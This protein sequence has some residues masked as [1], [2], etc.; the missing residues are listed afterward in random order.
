VGTDET[1]ALKESVQG[2]F[3]AAYQAQ[4]PWSQL[5]LR[6]RGAILGRFAPAI[7]ESRHAL[8]RLVTSP[9]R[10]DFRETISSELLPLA[11]AAKW[12]SSKAARILAIRYLD[13]GGSPTWLGRIRSEVHR[14]PHG[15]VLIIGTWNY[16]IFLTGVQILHAL[17]AGNAV[18]IKP[19][20]GCEEVTRAMVRMLVQCGVPERLLVVLDS[21]IEAAK[22]A[23]DIGVDHVIM[24]GSSSSGRAVLTQAIPSLTSA[25][26][27]LSGSDA[28]YVLPGADLHRVCDLL[29]FGLRLNGGATC[30]A[31]RR[32]FIPLKAS[33]VFHRVFLERLNEPVQRDWRTKIESSTHQRLWDGVADALDKGARIFSGQ[34]RQELASS[35]PVPDFVAMGHLVLTDV[36]TD[37]KLYSEDIFAPLIMI[38][39][40]ENW[41]GAL[42]ADSQC[43]FALSASIFGPVEDALRLVP[44]ISAG[45]VTIN[46]LIVPTADPRLPFGGRGESGFG[47]TRG[48]E[49][50][51]SM[52]TP[53][54]VS[55]RLGAWLPHAAL[56][57]P[58]DEQLLDGLLQFL[59]GKGW[60]CRLGG[61]RQIVQAIL[62]QRKRSK[63]ND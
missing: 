39:P 5:S 8:S 55:T 34:G 61:L 44:F 17:A 24:T 51:L 32:V 27:E 23:M 41:S 15:L 4:L 52:T 9:M 22:M 59:H 11:D 42:K 26:L 30:M 20:A 18:V 10:T 63:S 56:P 48:A 1:K 12:L 21:S 58:G 43:P 37:M 7:V 3:A 2:D 29:R 46:D 13:G 62:L 50:L 38:V 54:V 16:P 57:V 40:V 60:S 53:K 31:P 35:G 25:T 45:T 14:V 49:G 47:V 19:A 36:R 6:A 33:E 28:V